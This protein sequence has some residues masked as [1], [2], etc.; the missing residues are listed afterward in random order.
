MKSSYIKKLINQRNINNEAQKFN[1]SE[2]I[3]DIKKSNQFIRTI[4]WEAIH[5][6]HKL[7]PEAINANKCSIVHDIR[8]TLITT[9]SNWIIASTNHMELLRQCVLET[10]SKRLP[11]ECIVKQLDDFNYEISWI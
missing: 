10:L 6:K 3:S 7:I 4:D 2:F 9:M 5:I 8:P 11:Q 1:N